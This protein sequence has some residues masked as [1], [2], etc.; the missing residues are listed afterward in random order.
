MTA[1]A[2]RTCAPAVGCSGSRVASAHS[3]DGSGWKAL[4]VGN[5]TVG[6]DPVRAVVGEDQLLFRRGLVRLLSQAGFEV[7]AE[8]GDADALGRKTL[9]HRPD[10][11]VTDVRMPPGHGDD[12]LRAAI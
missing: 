8:A 2:T 1:V 5:A 7:G 12:G 11:V 10:L 6:G 9:A 3:T 4:A